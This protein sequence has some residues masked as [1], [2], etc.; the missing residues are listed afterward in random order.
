VQESFVMSIV[1]TWFWDLLFVE[2][3]HGDFDCYI[4]QVDSSAGT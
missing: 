4:N 3:S 1:G 2:G